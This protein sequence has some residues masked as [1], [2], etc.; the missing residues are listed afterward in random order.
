[1]DTVV[2][3]VHNYMYKII[4]PRVVSL[5]FC[6]VLYDVLNSLIFIRLGSNIAGTVFNI[7]QMGNVPK[8]WFLLLFFFFVCVFFFS[9]S[10]D[11]STNPV[12]FVIQTLYSLEWRNGDLGHAVYLHLLLHV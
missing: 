6:T 2:Y 8:L 10:F 11:V 1:M 12:S 3:Y 9:F 5:S 7:V 4:H